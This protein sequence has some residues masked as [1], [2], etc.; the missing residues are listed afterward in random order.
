MWLYQ[1]WVEQAVALVDASTKSKGRGKAPRA[2]AEACLATLDA[3][4]LPFA[5]VWDVSGPSQPAGVLTQ[6][7]LNLEV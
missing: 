7:V 6:A 5:L 2:T 4:P 1:W 3:L